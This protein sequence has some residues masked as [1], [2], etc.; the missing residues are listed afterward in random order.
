[1]LR[2]RAILFLYSICISIGLLAQSNGNITNAEYFWD[3]DPAVALIAS[4]GNFNSAVEDILSSSSTAFSSGGVHVF[5]IRVQ[6][7]NGNWGPTFRRV[8]II[9]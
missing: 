9:N 5:N 1:M 7:E 2:K 8:I 4:D 3:S 6:D